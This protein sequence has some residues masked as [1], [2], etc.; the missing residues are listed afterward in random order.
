M[1]A[2]VPFAPAP[3]ATSAMQQIPRVDVND[4]ARAIGRRA[5]DPER[6]GPRQDR[7]PEQQLAAV[8]RLRLSTSYP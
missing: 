3:L 2:A 6:I 7:W 4:H 8:E 1:P 5:P